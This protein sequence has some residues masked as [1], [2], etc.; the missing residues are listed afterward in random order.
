MKTITL[1]LQSWFIACVCLLGFYASTSIAK[2]DDLSE[3]KYLKIATEVDNV[4]EKDFNLLLNILK[5][6]HLVELAIGLGVIDIK[7]TKGINP[8]D[9]TIYDTNQALAHSGG[10]KEIRL[11]IKKKLIWLY[12]S[13]ATYPFKDNEVPYHDMVIYC[14]EKQGINKSDYQY[15]TTFQAEQLLIKKVIATH[16]DKLTAEQREKV[17]KN[18]ELNKLSASQKTAI[19]LGSGTTLL[20]VVSTTFLLS[21][22]AFYPTVSSVIC[23]TAGVIGLTVPFS[24][25]MGTSTAIGFLTGPVGWAALAVGGIGTALLA[26]GA[27]PQK[28]TEKIMV[29]HMLKAKSIMK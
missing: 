6:K 28:L 21:G 20:S 14:C 7:K 17:I 1:K 26:T 18:S 13:A 8:D 24:V 10:A 12:S 5:D 23:A 15:L 9:G 25:Y 29:I 16:W 22:F 19:I 27:N 11:N 2:A 4:S 3:Y